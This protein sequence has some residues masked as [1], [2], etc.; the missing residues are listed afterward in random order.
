ME[1]ATTPY[2]SCAPPSTIWSVRDSCWRGAFQQRVFMVETL[3]ERGADDDVAE[4]ESALGIVSARFCIR[5]L[6]GRHAELGRLHGDR[7]G[8]RVS[9][10]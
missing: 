7:R 10:Q 1:T 6:A 9:A 2:R 5:G 3:L 8:R 4:A